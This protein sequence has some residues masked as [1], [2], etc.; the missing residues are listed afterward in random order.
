MVKTVIHVN[1]AV[2]RKNRK[3]GSR[4]APLTVKTYKTNQYASEGEILDQ[5]GNV[6]ARVCYTTDAPLSCGAT[7]YIVALGEVR[8]VNK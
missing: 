6:V 8:V 2:I 1:Q 7:A 4:D 3:T 5:S